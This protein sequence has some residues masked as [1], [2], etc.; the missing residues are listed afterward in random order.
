MRTFLLMLPVSFAVLSG[1]VV[2]T[3]PGPGDPK[4][5]NVEQVVGPNHVIRQQ[6]NQN[7][8]LDVSSGKAVA[9]QEVQAWNCT[10]NTNQRWNWVTAPNGASNIQGIGNLCLDVYGGSTADGTPVNEYPCGNDKPNQTFRY[11]QNGHIREVQ[12]NKC[13]TV[14]PIAAGSPLILQSCDAN[15]QGQ[16]WVIQ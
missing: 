11:H 2:T 7:L 6:S 12:S 9:N 4:W 1:C 5:N 8:C 16:Y 3:Y 13:L 10:F 15:N 14:N